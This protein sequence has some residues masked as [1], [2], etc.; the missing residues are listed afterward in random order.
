MKYSTKK[1]NVAVWNRIYHLEVFEKISFL[2]LTESG[3]SLC[4]ENSVRFGCRAARSAPRG[5]DFSYVVPRRGLEPPWPCDRYHLKVVRLPI[6]PPRH[7]TLFKQPLILYLA[8]ACLSH[9]SSGEA[10]RQ[11]DLLSANWWRR[12]FAVSAKNIFIRLLLRLELLFCRFLFFLCPQQRQF[13]FF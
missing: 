5:I 1:E 3:I 10:D 12:G 6:S 9:R 7:K 4:S 13:S 11:A 8:T 2:L